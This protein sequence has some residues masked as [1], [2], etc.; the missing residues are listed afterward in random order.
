MRRRTAQ[1]LAQPFGR[2]ARNRGESLETGMSWSLKRRRIEPELMDEAGPE[3]AQRILRDLVRIN[4]RLGGHATIRK[5]LLRAGCNGGRFSLLDVGAASG[6]TAALIRR[7]FPSAQVT[8][9]DRNA[10]NLRTAGHPKV[11]ADAFRLPFRPRSFDFVFSSL[12]LHHF[13]DEQVVALIRSFSEIARQGVLLS[14][15]ERH[16]VPYWFMRAS[17]PFFGWHWMTVYDGRLSV[18]AAFKAK[19]LAALARSAGLRAVQVETHRP[20]FRLSLIGRIA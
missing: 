6:D 19:E 17:K 12:F 16:I 13:G 1:E 8:S 2:G 3:E 15:L 14:D 10:V 18:Q 11:L 4:A 9:L 7:Y 5:L 20:A